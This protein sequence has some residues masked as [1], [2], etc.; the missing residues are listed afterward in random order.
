M[1]V[2]VNFRR[3]VSR[4]AAKGNAVFSFQFS[5]FSSQFSVLSFRFSVFGLASRGRESAG[6]IFGGF[7]GGHLQALR[8]C[9]L[10]R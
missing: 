8:E 5:V 1:I 10:S 2:A 7:G 9:D 4:E 3:M 6:V